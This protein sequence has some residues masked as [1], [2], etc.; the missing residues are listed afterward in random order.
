MD[1]GIVI[2][3]GQLNH[4]N[5]ACGYRIE[6]A[7]KVIAICTDTEHFEDHIDENVIKLAQDADI[8]IYDS[9]YTND[10]YQ[11]FK[12]WGHSTWQEALK[13]ADAAKVKQ[14]F[15][16]HHDPSHNDERMDE[17][18][19]EVSLIMDGVRPAIEGETITV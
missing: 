10:E 18:A 17:I 11:K 8:M 5:G 3:T 19:K 7:G 1:G 6:Y 4:P 2:K 13:V 15:L 16:F 12:G 14:T 9:A